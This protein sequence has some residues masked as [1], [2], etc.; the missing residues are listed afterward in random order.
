MTITKKEYKGR[1]T[2]RLN[3][4]TVRVCQRTKKNI[5]IGMH[6]LKSLGSEESGLTPK[7][8]AL[9]KLYIVFLYL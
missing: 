7:F 3:A 6:S 8:F 2:T 1:G 9:D 5:T 4:K